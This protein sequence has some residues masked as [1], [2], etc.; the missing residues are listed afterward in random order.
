MKKDLKIIVAACDNN[1]IGNKGDL[2]WNLKGDM[3]YFREITT[4][5][6]EEDKK[7]GKSNVVIMGRKTWES[8]PIKFR[9]L[10][11]RI[12]FVLSSQA[13][14]GKNL[15]PQVYHATDLDQAFRMLE[16]DDTLKTKVASIFVIGGSS[17]YA[18]ALLSPRCETI[19]FTKIEAPFDCDT[20]FPSI[21]ASFKRISS[22]ENQETGISYSF[23]IYKR[24][25]GSA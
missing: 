3:K 7:V 4:R 25:P 1:G 15:P 14:Y 2:P 5:L 9:P 19:Y 13:D 12:N 17:L 6:D 24:E 20:F 23:E 22:H 21:P 10:A 16:E 11:S 8:I 18:T